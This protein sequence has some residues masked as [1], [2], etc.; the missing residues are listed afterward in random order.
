MPWAAIPWAL[1]SLI[2]VRTAASIYAAIAFDFFGKVLHDG[3]A[4][5]ARDSVEL[6]FF[7]DLCHGHSGKVSLIASFW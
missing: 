3:F 2:A 7:D 6:G 4:L 5:I 1:H